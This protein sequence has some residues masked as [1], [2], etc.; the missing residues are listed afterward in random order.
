[1][2]S[3]VTLIERSGEFATKDIWY[4]TVQLVTN[5]DN[6]HAYA[7]RKVVQALQRGASDDAVLGVA[8]YILGAYPSPCCWEWGSGFGI[9]LL[10]EL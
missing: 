9:T 10:C 4:S 1:M 6:L 5:H 2:D 8:A 7:A 3:M